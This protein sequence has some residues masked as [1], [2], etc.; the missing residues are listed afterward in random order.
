MNKCPLAFFP[1]L[2]VSTAPL[3]MLLPQTGCSTGDWIY[4]LSP[5]SYFRSA[6]LR[7]HFLALIELRYFL[8][9]LGKH[10]ETRARV[11]RNPA[12]AWRR[13]QLKRGQWTKCPNRNKG[14]LFSSYCEPAAEDT[15][16]NNRGL[17][18]HNLSSLLSSRRVTLARAVSVDGR[19]EARLC[20]AE[21]WVGG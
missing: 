2:H 13:K 18:L 1:Q 16:V 7:S 21:E 4:F 8:T 11:V 17:C 10:E 12:G 6:S 19:V 3:H 14:S 9:Y 5:V 15:V 20:W